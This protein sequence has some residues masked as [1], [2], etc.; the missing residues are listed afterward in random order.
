[1]VFPYSPSLTPSPPLSA[2]LSSVIIIPLL[3]FHVAFVFLSVCFMLLEATLH[4]HILLLL[5]LRK[6]LEPNG[7]CTLRMDSDVHD[8][9][10]GRN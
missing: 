1:M 6:F 3:P 4:V 7:R 9:F 10:I 8:R 2:Q 5:V